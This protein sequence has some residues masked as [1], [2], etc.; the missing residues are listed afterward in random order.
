FDC[1]TGKNIKFN[2]NEDLQANFP[3]MC[4]NSGSGG[5]TMIRA[6]LLVLKKKGDFIRVLAHTKNIDKPLD[7]S[8][9]FYIRLSNRAG[10]E[11]GMPSGI[12]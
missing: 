6:E 5:S 10:Q 8:Y 2:N 1:S 4:G 12:N 3:P 7:A 9:C 11:I